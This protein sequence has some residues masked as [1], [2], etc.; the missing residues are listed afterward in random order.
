MTRLFAGI[1]LTLSFALPLLGQDAAPDPS[2]SLVVDYERPGLLVPHWKIVVPPRGMAQY[3][4]VPTKGND[5]GL[6]TFRISDAGRARLATMLGRSNGMAPCE[7]KSKGIANMGIKTIVYTPSSGSP[8]TCTFNYTDNKP[9]SEASSYLIGLSDTL[10]TGLE[11]ER[12]HRY[13][14]LGL[15]PAILRL[16]DEVKGGHATELTAIRP[17]LESLVTD[18]AILE[19]VR[20]KAQQLLDLAKLDETAAP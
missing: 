5:P 4:G 20:A 11:L 16:M 14:R 18:P 2:Y 19:R 10:Q 12:L 3:T 15:D 6:V 13:D 17:T 7:T 8:V 9:L 1:A